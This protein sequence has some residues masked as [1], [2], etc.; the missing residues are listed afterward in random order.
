MVWVPF[1][2]PY[3][4]RAALNSGAIGGDMIFV[5]W[6]LLDGLGVVENMK[7]FS[8]NPSVGLWNSFY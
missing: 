1:K 5:G 7:Q 2:G 8:Y 6:G 3:A 4:Q